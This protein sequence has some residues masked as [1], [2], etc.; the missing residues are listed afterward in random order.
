MN[1]LTREWGF[2]KLFPVR[3]CCA[4]KSHTFFGGKTNGTVQ[5]LQRSTNT[6]KFSVKFISKNTKPRF[7]L[8][9]IEKI[10]TWRLMIIAFIYVNNNDIVFVFKL[11]R[12]TIEVTE[13]IEENPICRLDKTIL[14]IEHTDATCRRR[15]PCENFQVT[16]QFVTFYR[17]IFS[18]Q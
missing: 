6:H 9:I 13:S 17:V 12:S 4:Y 15:C 8:R 2:N 10:K 14:W 1:G 16:R 7:V 3:Y 18:G 11:S 5:N